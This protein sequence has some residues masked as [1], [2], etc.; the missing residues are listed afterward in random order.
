MIPEGLSTKGKWAWKTA[1]A[2]ERITAAMMR[3]AFW[4]AQFEDLTRDVAVNL[5]DAASK[6]RTGAVATTAGPTPPNVPLRQR[7]ADDD[8][9]EP[10]K[11]DAKKCAACGATN[12]L[13]AKRCRECG[14]MFLDEPRQPVKNRPSPKDK[15]PSMHVPSI[16]RALDGVAD[17]DRTLALAAF[18]AG[19]QAG[20][21]ATARA[22]MRSRGQ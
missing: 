8:D 1:G 5:A 10:D 2:N 6:V 13:D 4:E 11:D 22:I 14:A 9:D 15:R 17:D 18:E 20:A 12:E 16:H 19:A 21:L 3:P 7:Q